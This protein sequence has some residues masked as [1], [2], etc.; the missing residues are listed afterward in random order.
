M[1][2]PTPFKGALFVGR[3][4]FLLKCNPTTFLYQTHKDSNPRLTGVLEDALS[5]TCSTNLTDQTYALISY[6]GAWEAH[7]PTIQSLRRQ[8]SNPG[9]DKRGSASQN[10]L[11]TFLLN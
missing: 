9:P 6:R 1:S 2:S 10:L 11:F 3:S 5:P 4:F 7:I 8:W